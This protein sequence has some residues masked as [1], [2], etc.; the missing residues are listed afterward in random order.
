[1][2]LK[3]IIKS[4]K[5][6]YLFTPTKILYLFLLVFFSLFLEILG[7]ALIIPISTI[8]LSPDKINYYKSLVNINFFSDFVMFL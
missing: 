2:W 4:L 8:L 7:V 1:M 6:T 5:T 3:L